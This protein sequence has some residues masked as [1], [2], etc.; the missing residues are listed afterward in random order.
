MSKNLVIELKKPYFFEDEEYA[1]IDLSGMENLTMQDAIEAQKNVV[2]TGEDSVILYAPEASQAFIDEI[3]AMA[4]KQPVEF[5]NGMPIGLSDKVRTA[6]QGMFS[7]DGGK[8]FSLK[9]GDR[10]R[11]RQSKFAMGLVRLSKKSFCEILDYK[12]G[13]CEK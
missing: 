4:A 13:G 3:A 2:G 12:M 7:A 8:A 6:V 11:V 1:T 5:F 9:N 10:V